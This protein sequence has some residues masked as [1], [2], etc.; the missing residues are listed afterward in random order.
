MKRN[1]LIVA[2]ASLLAVSCTSHYVAK[3]TVSRNLDGSRQILATRPDAD[4]KGWRLDSLAEPQVFDFRGDKDTMRYAYS[5]DVARD[6]WT[7]RQDS[8]SRWLQPEVTVSKS[9]RWFTTRYTYT[10]RFRQI[11]GLPVPIGD[12]LTPDEQRLLF[13][14]NELPADWT[15][16]DLYALLDKLNTKYVRWWNHCLFEKEMEAYAACSNSEQRALLSQY[17]DTLLA[18][19]LSDLPDDR[20]AL[21][22]VCRQFPELSFVEDIAKSDN[23]MS[24]IGGD[25]AFENLNLDTRVLWRVELPGGRIAEHMVGAERAIQGDYM[26]EETGRTINWWA[27]ILT[28]VLLLAAVWLIPRGALCG[29]GRSRSLRD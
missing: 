24:Y 25:W 17:H 3:D 15:G 11:E 18:I 10:A 9:F 21:H 27:C 2:A 7:I 29:A 19:I 16:C 22:M 8:L 6:G 13:S 26:I 5:M 20:K 28:F 23:E 1:I 12:Y 14:P 4:F